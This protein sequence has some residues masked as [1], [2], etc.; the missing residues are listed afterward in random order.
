[1]F[2]AIDQFV[3]IV[4]MEPYETR[5]DYEE[6]FLPERGDRS[7]NHPMPSIFS[8]LTLPRPPS[9]FVPL[10]DWQLTSTNLDQARYDCLSSVLTLEMSG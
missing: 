3:V 5:K 4:K 1:M 8:I 7:I 10:A 9:R 2:T 6:L